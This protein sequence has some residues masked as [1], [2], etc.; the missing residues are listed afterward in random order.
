MSDEWFD[1]YLYEIVVNKRYLQDE[2]VKLYEEKE[3]K[4]LPPWDPMGALA[5]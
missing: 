3:A 5:K 2:Y 4:L 1:E